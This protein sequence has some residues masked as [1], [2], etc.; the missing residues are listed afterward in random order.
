MSKKIAV[1]CLSHF[2]G[3]MEIDALK[4]TKHFNEFGYDCSLICRASTFLEQEAKSRDIQHHAIDFKRKLDIKL[5]KGLRRVVQ[6]EKISTLVF[7][8]TSEIKSIYFAV[9]GLDCKVIVRH[10]TTMSSPKKD[11][12]HSLFYSCTD[13]YV[14]ISEHLRRNIY[15]I[16]PTNGKPVEAIYNFIELPTQ[17]KTEREKPFL[18]VGRV[19]KG[20][21]IE[22]AIIALGKA[23]ID[24][25]L[26]KLTAVGSCQSDY[27]KT[28]ERLASEHG[29]QLDLAGF[30]NKPELMYLSH[31]YFLFPSHGEGLGNVI[32]EALSYGLQC[33]SY[34]NTVFPELKEIGF[35]NLHLAKD[36]DVDE[37]AQALSSVTTQTFVESDYDILQCRF[38]KQASFENWKKVL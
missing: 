6:Y 33:I 37:L 3:G 22:D 26:K 19:E 14:G 31:R 18:F 34:S 38:S 16:F 24:D 2:E 35:N 1:L 32:L 21:G 11:F 27:V 5:I 12:I 17:V 10:G 36:R 29:I 25:S 28:L 8:G 7:F 9:K 4:Y 30:T 13:A 23:N 15:D 20:K